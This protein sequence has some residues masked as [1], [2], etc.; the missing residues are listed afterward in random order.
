VC[1]FVFL[2][3]L[4]IPTESKHICHLYQP[5]EYADDIPSDE[6]EDDE[7]KYEPIKCQKCSEQQA[8]LICRSCRGQFM[9]E[10][11]NRSCHTRDWQS[12]IR[13]PLTGTNHLLALAESL[14]SE[15]VGVEEIKSRVREMVLTYLEDRK[16]ARL[17]G[18]L[19]VFEP[20]VI[21]LVGTQEQERPPSQTSLQKCLSRWVCVPTA[22]SCP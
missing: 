8:T 20:P 6:E 1:P 15:L 3:S 9:C 18:G 17:R 7:Q 14:L 12:H 16:T 2:L 4:P 11:C 19:H 21:L 10:I 5:M 13:E 22:P